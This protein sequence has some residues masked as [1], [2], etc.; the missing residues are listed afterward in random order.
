M[1]VLDVVPAGVVDGKD[2]YKLFDYCRE[3][4]FAIPAFNVT[5]SS[6]ANAAMEAA[7]DAKSP[8]ILQVSQGGAAFFAGKGLANDKQQASIAGA[9]A[10]ANHVRAVAESYG[11]PVVL[12]SDHC[13]KK[14]LPWFDGMLEADEANFAKEGKPL[15]SSHMLDLS[16]ETKEENIE[17][18]LKY[19][20]RMAKIGVWLE[21]EIGITGGEEDGVNNE[22]VDNASLYTQPEDIW[23]IYRQFS[24]V[25]PNFSIAAG[26]GNVHGVYKP[27][28]VSLQPDL[29]RKHQ[30]YVREQLKSDKE[31][32]VFLVFH[33]GSGS[34]KHEI[35]TAVKNGV[36]K[37]NVDTDTQFAY[38]EGIRDFVLN[39]K[40][41]LMSQVGNPEGA[42]KPNKKQYDPRVWVREGEKTMS[43]RCKIAFE[44]LLSA[45]QL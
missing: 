12:H 17:T 44:D 33:G 7:R 21:M 32:P 34:E 11:I 42:D 14:L 4:H 25:T 1:G 24:E 27:G 19:L 41:Y 39:K 22:N 35:T 10:A 26:F 36:V 31:L 28:N 23:D 8:V 15:F 37:M 20:P 45:G 30:D 16:E 29:L 3:N 40:D 38:L 6:V 5:S 9:V 2:V 13:A 43:K 18:C